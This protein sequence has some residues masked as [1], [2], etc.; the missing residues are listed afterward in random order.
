MI[1][2]ISAS[3]AFLVLGIQSNAQCGFSIDEVPVV[4]FT[5]AAPA[6]WSINGQVN[7]W[8]SVF[9]A[10]T[11]NPANPYLST[12]INNFFRETQPEKDITQPN[13]DL[14]FMGYTYDDHNLYI[15]MR[16][17][18]N[19]G[20]PIAYYFFADVNFD[21]YMNTGEPVIGGRWAGSS[22]VEIAGYVPNTTIDYVA[23][24]GNPLANITTMGYFVNGY[25]MK[26]TATR[27]FTSNQVPSSSALLPGEV[28]DAKVTEDGFGIE[29]SIPWR[30]L[31]NWVSGSAPLEAGDLFAYHASTQNGPVNANTTYNPARVADNMGSCCESIPYI[32]I[33][34][35]SVADYSSIVISPLTR[36]FMITLSNPK[37]ITEVLAINSVNFSN[38][39]LNGALPLTMSD[40]TVTVN[41][42]SFLHDFISDGFSGMGAGGISVPAGGTAVFNVDVTY[43]ANG[44]VLG[45]ITTIIPAL[46]LFDGLPILCRPVELGGGPGKPPIIFDNTTEARTPFTAISPESHTT[47]KVFPN[48]SNGLVTVMIPPTSKGGSLRVEDLNGRLVRESRGLYISAD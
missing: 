14:R 29:M 15:Y 3:L 12:N 47:I 44:V 31:K 48:P 22:P 19:G 35:L 28:F 38:L 39:Q 16:R 8:T 25:T 7:D 41:G 37:N 10:F 5:G 30:F 34:A 43:P 23:G 6:P 33:P 21:G 13:S 1:K 18:S 11:G 46:P 20:Q 4:K 45:A 2:V 27:L 17:M 26:G 42:T 24:K 40:I 32:E 9:G 36:R